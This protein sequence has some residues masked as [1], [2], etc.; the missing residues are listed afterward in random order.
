MRWL[1]HFWEF[2]I[3]VQHLIK[4][5]LTWGD[6]RDGFSFFSSMWSKTVDQFIRTRPD[7]FSAFLSNFYPKS[8]LYMGFLG[9]SGFKPIIVICP[10]V[11]LLIGNYR[12]SL[13]LG[14]CLAGPL[15]LSKA[16]GIL[17]SVVKVSEVS[18]RFEK[19]HPLGH[20][21]PLLAQ[22]HEWNSVLWGKT[23][24]RNKAIYCSFLILVTLASQC[25]ITLTSWN[26]IRNTIRI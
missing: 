6:F 23:I 2:F 15:L 7:M 5:A 21:D 19:F 3:K 25:T 22:F 4:D 17:S 14:V 11:S 18:S 16:S 1:I 10:E 8:I 13:Y 24:G 9:S 26:T 12:V 20:F